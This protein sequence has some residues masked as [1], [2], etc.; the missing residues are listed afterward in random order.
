MWMSCEEWN[1]ILRE[2]ER[3]VTPLSYCY[4]QRYDNAHEC[5]FSN[6][7]NHSFPSQNPS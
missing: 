5:S 2:S 4:I 1:P 7:R 3:H 6:V